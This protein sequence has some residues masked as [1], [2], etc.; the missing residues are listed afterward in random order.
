MRDNASTVFTPDSQ[1]N[2]V[3]SIHMYGVC[4]TASEAT[5]LWTRPGRSASATSAGRG[6]A[7]AAG[8]RVFNGTNGIKSTARQVTVY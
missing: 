3:F 7:T 5:S 2:T 8:N 4:D 6:G 1:R